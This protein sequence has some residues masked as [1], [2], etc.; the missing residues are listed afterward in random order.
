MSYIKDHEATYRRVLY[1]ASCLKSV[2]AWVR[3]R[4]SHGHLGLTDEVRAAGKGALGRQTFGLVLLVVIEGLDDS[5]SV[6]ADL[7]NGLQAFVTL[8]GGPAPVLDDVEV[9]IDG[10]A[11]AFAWEAV[12]AAR[13]A[14]LESRAFR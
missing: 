1:V 13:W 10:H 9:I 6:V 11:P 7:P 12:V 14:S 8:P 2:P 4:H 3:W 5:T